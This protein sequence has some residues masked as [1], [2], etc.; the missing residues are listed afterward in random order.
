MKKETKNQGSIEWTKPKLASFKKA[1]EEALARQDE[2]FRW[3]GFHFIP[4]YAKYLIEWL[5]SLE[6]K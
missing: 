3:Q 2:Q 4:G 5:E 6:D 1:Y